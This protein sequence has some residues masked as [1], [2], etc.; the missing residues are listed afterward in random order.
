MSTPNTPQEDSVQVLADAIS[1]AIGESKGEKRFIDMTKIPL[2]CASIV[3]IH[4]NIKEIKNMIV[5]NKKDSDVQHESFVT[6]E[7][8]HLNFDTVRTLVYGGVGLALVAV[9]GAIV[10]LVIK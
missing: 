8:L 6:K 3:G 1:K 2:I 10:S 5:D 7:Y 4:E 9:V